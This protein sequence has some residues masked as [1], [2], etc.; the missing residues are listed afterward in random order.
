MNQL[1]DAALA[2]AA[3]GWS[4]FP[5]MAKTKRPLTLNGFKDASTDPAQIQTWWTHYPDANIGVATGARSGIS[6][7]DVDI[8]PWKDKHGDETIRAL[9]AQYGSLPSTPSQYTWS[10][11]VQFIFQDAGIGSGAGRIGKDLDHRGDGGYIVVAPSVVE[12]DGRD[13]MYQWVL[14]PEAASPA[15]MPAWLVEATKPRYVEKT[16]AR[17]P[18]IVE[19]LAGVS[20]GSRNDTGGRLAGY[21]LGKGLPEDVVVAM[22]RLWG[23]ACDPPLDAD[24]WTKL[25]GYV[26]RT[27]AK[28]PDP[29]EPPSSIAESIDAVLEGLL[30]PAEARVFAATGIASFDDLLGGG[31][32]DGQLILL[33]ARPKVGKTA[34][35]CQIARNLAK[36]GTGVFVATLEMSK[37]QIIRRMFVQES[38]VRASAVKTG[39]L[40]DI[41]RKMLTAAADRLRGLPLWFAEDTRTVASLDDALSIYPPGA[42]GCVVVDY[43]QLMAADNDR[44]DPR[45][46]VE[47]VGRGLK[48]L[49]KKYHAPFL[50]L[51][52]LSRP[53]KRPD[54][55]P[56]LASLRESGELEHLGDV[57]FFLH[58]P[59]SEKVFT[60]LIVAG[61]REG[62]SGDLKLRF[63]GETQTFTEAAGA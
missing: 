29:A 60:D 9:Q 19:A 13:G 47:A 8:K 11:G 49:A 37:T 32:E 25:E 35:A 59:E 46:R 58:R 51:S 53:E 24:E 2:Y 27:A 63:S 10:G 55:R 56:N 3:R 44:L 61:A 45:Q 17:E 28:E 41:E 12:E 62:E 31:F 43:L 36:K 16:G 7:L 15:P 38:Q 34:L 30:S 21:W 18:W 22:L 14:P 1:L 54:W 39:N 50:V 23:D 48:R 4:V 5:L 42:L 33:G 6:V 52:S 26:A 57:I 20:D 40:V